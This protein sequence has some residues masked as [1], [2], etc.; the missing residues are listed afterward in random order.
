M[1]IFSRKPIIITETDGAADEAPRF[2][3]TLSCAVD[4]FLKLNLD[5]YVHGV[6]AA[7]LS[8]FNP[9]E[10]RM[11]PLSHDLCGLV[12]PHDTFGNHLDGSGKTIDLR[13]E[14][15]NFHAAAEV[16]SEVWS[17]TVI[18]K[19]EVNCKAVKPGSSFKPKERSADWL[20]RHVI[21]SRYSLQIVKCFDPDCCRPFETNWPEIFPQRFIP[22]PCI[23]GFGKKGLEVVEPSTYFEEQLKFENQTKYKFASLQERLIANLKSEEAGK[24]KQGN[25]FLF[26]IKISISISNIKDFKLHFR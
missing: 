7:G 3:K 25:N 17:N 11:A 5:A 13:L 26:T 12:L 20:S 4:L 10:R 15:K 8:A 14:K 21:Q 9:V 2:P 19:C 23:Y 1:T 18:D 16:L 6:N 24:N 22:A